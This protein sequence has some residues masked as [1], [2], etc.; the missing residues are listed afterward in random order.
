MA[1]SALKAR[2]LI[3]SFHF[4]NRRYRSLSALQFILNY[5][6]LLLISDNNKSHKFHEN[7]IK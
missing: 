1:S 3:S 6:I 7:L 5:D 2:I 4:K